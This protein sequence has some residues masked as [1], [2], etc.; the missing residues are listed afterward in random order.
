MIIAH[1]IAWD[2]NNN[3]ATD[4]A[5]A[6]GTARV[7]SLGAGRGAEAVRGMAADPVVAQ[8]WPAV[9]ASPRQRE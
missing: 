2:P 4:F 8:A 3:Q 9:L 7:A 6:A 1:K 5:K